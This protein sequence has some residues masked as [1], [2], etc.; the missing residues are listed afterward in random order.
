MHRRIQL[1]VDGFQ[2][3]EK[4][5]STGVPQGSPAS[6]I[7]FAIYI[8]GVFEAIEAAVPG[9]KALSFSDDVGIVAPASSVDQA[10]EKLQRAGEAAIA[11]SRTKA[12]QFDTEKTET[13]LFTRKRGRQLREQVKQASIQ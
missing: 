4:L 6:P 1:V 11:W 5:V 7:L 2:C 8:S 13:M 9:V 3:A 12:V 10:C